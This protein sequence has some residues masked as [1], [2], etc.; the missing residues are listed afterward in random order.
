MTTAQILFTPNTDDD[1]TASALAALRVFVSQYEQETTPAEA[2]AHMNVAYLSAKKVLRRGP[3]LASDNIFAAPANRVAMIHRARE[4]L[5]SP[6]N[7]RTYGVFVKKS[8][9]GEIIELDA[10]GVDVP[11]LIDAIIAK[12]PLART[13][14]IEMVTKDDAS[15]LLQE[16]VEGFHDDD[17]IYDAVQTLSDADDFLEALANEINA[18]FGV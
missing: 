13:T 3:M 5:L 18:R 8:G 10:G 12:T 2:R 7:G 9:A 11:A 4:H 15:R 6:P 1:K 16:A 17:E 14:E